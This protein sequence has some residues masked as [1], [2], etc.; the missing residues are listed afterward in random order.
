MNLS[1]YYEITN[2]NRLII[3]T[4]IL[5]I[6]YILLLFAMWFHIKL[7]IYA[8]SAVCFSFVLLSCFVTNG[9]Y[10]V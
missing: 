10:A 7:L 6:G 3:S 5:A 9:W 1:F 8:Y 2:Q 4:E